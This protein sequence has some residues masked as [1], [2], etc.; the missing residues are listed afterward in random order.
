MP[1]TEEIREIVKAEVEKIPDEK[2]F[3]TMRKLKMKYISPEAVEV[4]KYAIVFSQIKIPS[5]GDEIYRIPLNDLT[6]RYFSE[7]KANTRLDILHLLGDK[8]CLTLL[9]PNKPSLLTWVP[10]ALFMQKYEG[11]EEGEPNEL[12][13]I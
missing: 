12:E 4:M 8:K 9:R 7:S 2:I 1:T 11:K 5:E 6:L 13:Q 10:S 3:F